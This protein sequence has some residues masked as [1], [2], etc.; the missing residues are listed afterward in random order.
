MAEVYPRRAL[1]L[2]LRQEE[3]KDCCVIPDGAI[4]GGGIYLNE[5]AKEVL[6][7]C[8]GSS[9]IDALAG[10]FETRYSGS[11][12][13][14][15][16]EGV[17]ST[18]EQLVDF[19]LV[20][21]RREPCA[22]CEVTE[23]KAQLSLELVYFEVTRACN[24]RCIHCYNE[25]GVKREKELKTEE[26]LRIIESLAQA[27]VVDV[28]LTGGEPFIRKDIF[29]IIK[30]IKDNKMRFSVFTN[31]ILISPAIAAELAAY[32][33]RFVAISLDGA[34]AKIHE[35][36]RGRSTFDKTVRAIK[37]LKSNGI[38]VRINH[39]LTLESTAQLGGFMKLM[40]ELG[41]DDVY[42]DRFDSLG[43]GKEH[44][45]MVIPVERGSEIKSIIDKYSREENV[46]VMNY[47]PKVNIREADDGNMCGVG[48]SSC[49]IKANGEMSFCPVMSAEEFTVGNVL[50]NSVALLWNSGKWNSLRGATAD[51]IAGCKE[52]PGKSICL[53][54]CKAKA[55][56]EFGSFSHPD[57]WSCFQLKNLFADKNN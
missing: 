42:F 31:G 48:L 18:I 12:R 46:P 25:A 36:I 44:A 13:E 23:K 11:S 15:I 10:K 1:S 43:R 32:E 49:Y 5:P 7:H 39:T 37:M 16:K 52:C 2:I 3:G 56:N 35:K 51:T 38:K 19:G 9:D 20:D 47:S 22:S 24:L 45:G 53:G 30:A 21:L 41:V 6:L 17:I 26:I 34:E 27:G 57:R 28:V 54:G 55:Y 33:P 14:E 29:T 4:E 40:G 8:D 50:E